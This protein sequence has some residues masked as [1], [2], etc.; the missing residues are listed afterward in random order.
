[1]PKDVIRKKNRQKNVAPSKNKK[2]EDV[3]KKIENRV[4][5]TATQE[6]VWN[7]RGNTKDVHEHQ[8]K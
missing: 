2:K 5:Y 8:V 3:N 4:V 6:L 7:A 1:M